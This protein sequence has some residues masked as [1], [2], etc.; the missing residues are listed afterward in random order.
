MV[1]SLCVERQLCALLSTIF[2]IGIAHPQ[3]LVLEPIAPRILRDNWVFV[4]SQKLYMGFELVS[5]PNTC[6]IQGSAVIL[7][8]LFHFMSFVHLFRRS[9]SVAEHFS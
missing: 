4:R 5:T 9:F 6:I 2:C 1:W 7:Y 8:A 3:I